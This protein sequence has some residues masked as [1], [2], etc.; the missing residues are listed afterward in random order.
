MIPAICIDNGKPDCLAFS[1]ILVDQIQ[2]A[3]IVYAHRFRAFLRPALWADE[4][5]HRKTRLSRDLSILRAFSPSKTAELV[6]LLRSDLHAR[7][8]NHLHGPA[9][10]PQRS[11]GFRN[12][13]GATRRKSSYG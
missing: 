7:F 1:C 10:S 11:A 3:V 8:G 6:M 5:G 9:R 4:D 2:D 12:K 13:V